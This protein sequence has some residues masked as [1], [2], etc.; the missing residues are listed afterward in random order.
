MAFGHLRMTVRCACDT[1]SPCNGLDRLK[2][3]S[4]RLSSMEDPGEPCHRTLSNGGWTRFGSGEMNIFVEADQ[5]A[6]AFGD[7]AAALADY[8]RWLLTASQECVLF[9]TAPEG[10]IPRW[11]IIDKPDTLSDF[12]AASVGISMMRSGEI[13]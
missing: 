5:P 13:S 1:S 2:L 10:S 6:E 9:E 7:A 11:E 8:P 3:T 12:Q 4:R